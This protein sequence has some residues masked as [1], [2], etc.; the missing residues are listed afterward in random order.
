MTP[1][2]DVIS[3][4]PVVSAKQIDI[5]QVKMA[6]AVQG[7]NRHYRWDRI[8]RR[9]WL[10]TAGKCRF[11]PISM[12][13]ILKECCDMAGDCMMTVKEM[14]PKGFPDHIAGAIFTGLMRARDR[15]VKG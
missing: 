12:E 13:L 1:L 6:M 14:I 7:N 11:D 2:Y 15:L 8:V 4:Y 5:Q 9:H 10:E 3:I